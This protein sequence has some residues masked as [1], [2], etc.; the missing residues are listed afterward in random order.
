MTGNSDVSEE[1][2][3]HLIAT[4]RSYFGLRS[5]LKSHLLSRKTKILIYKALVRPVFTY[6]T[7]TLTMTKNDERRQSFFKRILFHR[8]YGPICEREQ[9]KKRYNRI[10]DELY[11][12]PN[13]VNVIKFSRLMW[14]GHVVR[15]DEKKLPKKI[16]WTNPGGQ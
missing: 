8:I 16:L 15:M 2:T 1:I 3:N 5:W 10:L 14:V 13:I 9:W 7:E 12:E 4:N 11:N 6:T